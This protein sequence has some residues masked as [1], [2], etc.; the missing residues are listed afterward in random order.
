MEKQ[1]TEF[2]EYI[3]FIKD[4]VIALLI[5][6]IGWIVSKWGKKLTYRMLTV[7]KLDEAL[8]RF[9]S[10]IIQYVILAAAVISSLETVGVQ[11]TS[12][13][14]I[15]ASAGLAIGLALQGSLSNF[16]SGVM[17]LFFRP[18]NL[19][20][21]ITAAGHTGAVMNI[22]VFTTT[23]LTLDNEK[24]II[25]NS[26]ITSGSI[27]NFAAERTLRGCVDV[28]IHYGTDIGAV[29]DVLKKAA[30]R[31][32]C[33]LKDPAPAIAFTELGASALNFKVF[34]WCKWE[35]YLDMLHHVRRAVYEDLDKAGIK[36]PYQQIVIHQAKPAA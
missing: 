16:S 34:A 31:S 23:L 27:V 22:G 24:I 35:D 5:L 8:A 12:L 15:L 10:G 21:K 11:T 25:P 26:S 6:S 17:L 2:T 33:V 29:I 9:L 13:V 36:I 30:S 20:D 32:A 28:G 1:L 3:P 14:A 7:K 18:F 19:G 4:V